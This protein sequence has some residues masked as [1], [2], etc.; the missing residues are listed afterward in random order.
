MQLANESQLSA[1]DT[2]KLGIKKLREANDR[3]YDKTIGRGYL[4]LGKLSEIVGMP[5]DEVIKQYNNVQKVCPTW[6]K[7]YFFLAKYYDSIIL[8]MESVA[9]GRGANSVESKIEIDRVAFAMINY[10]IA[11]K[12]GARYLFHSL[13]RVLTLWS[14]VRA[15]KDKINTQKV[16]T[17]IMKFHSRDAG[18]SPLPSFI[19][20]SS[21]SQLKSLYLNPSFSNC[22]ILLELLKSIIK[23]YPSQTI[24][25]FMD[26]LLSDDKNNGEFM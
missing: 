6:E 18:N 1:M 20:L 13:P 23:K 4:L 5:G 7:G 16:D 2:L 11:L 12:Y 21:L 3:S 15:K 8:S 25:R 26:F 19:W 22:S 14:M 10:L 24:W 17:I 9:D